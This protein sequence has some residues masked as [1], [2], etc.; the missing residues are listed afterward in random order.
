PEVEV[1]KEKGLA[2][3]RFRVD[4]D[5]IAKFGD[6]IINGATPDESE[7]LKSSLRSI[8]ARMTMSAIREGK[9]FSPKTLDN[10]TAF[11][12]SHLQNENH[13]AAQVKLSG[14]SYRAEQNRADIMFDVVPGPLVHADVQG[15]HLW[16]WTKHKLL[17]IYQQNGLTPELIQE[18]R[19]NLLRRFR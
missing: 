16:P 7:H 15:A 11:L 14:A 10:A 9:D 18:G 2:N 19:Q 4:L 13:L 6:I 8:R 12:E 3:V 17:P 5:K 1:D